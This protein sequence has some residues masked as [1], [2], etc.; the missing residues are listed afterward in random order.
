MSPQPGAGPWSPLGAPAFRAFWLAI[1]GGTIGTWVHDVA[2][3]WVMAENTGSPFM[4]AAVQAATTLPMVLLAI[5]AGTLADIVDRRRYLI[6]AQLWMVLVAGTIATFAHFDLL[7]PWLL[8]ALT[9]G[10]G[11]GAAMAAPAQ[12]ALTPELVP[13]Q[14]LAPAVALGS[15]SM[16]IARSVG[17]ALGGLIVAQWSVSA[18]FAVNAVSFLGIVVVLFR[19]TPAP[20]TSTAAPEPFG[21]ALRAGLRYATHASALQSVLAKAAMFFVAASAFN[22]LLPIVVNQDLGVGAG[23][24]GILL[25]CFGVGA[26]VGAL[27]L[28]GLRER[29]DPDRLVL[30]ATLVFAAAI[31]CLALVRNVWALYAMCLVAG[32]AWITVLSSFH[33]GAQTSL[34]GWVRARALALYVMVFSGGLAAGSL[35]WGGLAEWQG[36]TVAL[37]VAAGAT[38]LAAFAGLGFD[39]GE[40]GRVNVM[41]SGHWPT[42]IVDEGVEGDRGPVL[43]TVEYRIPDVHRGEFN[44][45]MHRLGRTRRR[46]G[47]ID[48]SVLE[49]ASRRGSFIEYFLA[50]SWNEHLRQH[51][52]VTLYERDLQQAIAALQVD[53]HVPLVRHFVGG[54]VVID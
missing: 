16:N 12:Q 54:T 53:G 5:I 10:M 23:V 3:A 48:W 41:P 44:A 39:L 37:L 2:A 21:S 36:T 26:V 35:V 40:A 38:V 25:A 15:L 9:F 7:T 18:A 19:W 50:G 27:R 33:I 1:L 24:Y 11:I 8:V 6:V 22:A 29:I 34:P 28:P 30:V 42:P 52:R 4:V 47:A 20:A 46:D 45:L 14:Q 17:P 51:E 49:D 31:A 32:F 13:R 43:V